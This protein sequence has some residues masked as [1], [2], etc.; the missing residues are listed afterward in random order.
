M[1]KG[2]IITIIIASLL[3]VSVLFNVYNIIY[4][5]I[6]NKPSDQYSLTSNS[7]DRTEYGGL[8]ETDT[9]KTADNN[10]MLIINSNITIKAEDNGNIDKLIRAYVK[11][12]N[13]KIVNSYDYLTS[14]DYKVY[15]LEVKIPQDLY[16]DFM[17]YLKQQ[18]E[19]VNLYENSYDVANQYNDNQL[20]ITMYENKLTRLYEL[21]D[22]SADMSDLITIEN[23][24]SDTIYQ[25]ESLK[26]TQGDLE[27]NNEFASVSITINPIIKETVEASGLDGIFGDAF[28]SSINGF[29]LFITWMIKIIFFI[30]PYTLIC[31]LGYVAYRMIRKNKKNE[32]K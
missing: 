15:T 9:S 2:K 29:I 28:T 23:A 31:G 7:Y 25:I 8:Y 30:L 22:Q 5:N 12:N 20:R 19:V 1:K 21:L 32:Q 18:G 10:E 3:V 17:E 4:G 27:Y 26:R 16:N 24:I 6:F 13:G 14:E 11:D